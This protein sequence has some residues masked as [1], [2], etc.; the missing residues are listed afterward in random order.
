M[1]K[2]IIEGRATVKNSTAAR[3]AFAASAAERRR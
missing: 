3:P 2:K 1:Q